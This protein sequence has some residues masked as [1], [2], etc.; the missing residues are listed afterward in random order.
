VQPDRRP[1]P[2]LG[3]GRTLRK[4]RSVVQ[5]SLMERL[6]YRGDFFFSWFMELV[7]MATS[8]LLWEAVFAGAGQGRLAGFERREMIAYLLLV[9]LGRLFRTPGMALRF[10]HE[11]RDGTLQK[12]LLQPI[13]LMAYQL[14]VWTAH[15]LAYVAIACFPYALLFFLCRSYF[16]AWPGPAPLA[17]YAVSLVLGFLVSF[18][19]EASLGMAGFWFLEVTGFVY[20]VNALNYFTSGQLLPLDVLPP[21]W[22]AAFRALPFQYMGYF[23]AMVFLGKVQGTELVF[24]LLAELSWALVFF[25]LA[26][27]L[28]QRGLR[29]YSAYGG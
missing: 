9:H 2:T 23:P 12:Y 10:A 1:L 22:A 25:G 16:T 7:S 8:I 17:G 19:F 21:F 14:A 5:V 27:W 13:D 11:I 20:V 15:R 3:V 28:Y 24:G 18:F 29:R 4:Y 26:R 6:T